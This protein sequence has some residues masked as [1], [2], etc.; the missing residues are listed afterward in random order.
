MI[1]LALMAG[2]F[3]AAVLL[4]GYASLAEEKPS[5]KTPAPIKPLPPA[6]PNDPLKPQEPTKPRPSDKTPEPRSPAVMGS[7]PDEATRA[8]L[9]KKVDLDFTDVP[10]QKIVDALSTQTK[11][12]I[13]VAAKDATTAADAESKHKLTVHL[14]GISA[15]NALN[16][17]TRDAG[18]GWFADQGAVV[19]SDDDHLPT[20]AQVYNVRDLV[21]AHPSASGPADE[22]LDY[23]Y[24]SLADVITGAIHSPTWSGNDSAVLQDC[25]PFHGTLTLTQDAQV[26]DQVAGLLAALRKSRDLRP[27]Q[28]DAT[29]NSGLRILDSDESSIEKALAKIVD[30]QPTAAKLDDLADWLRKTFSIAVHVDAHAREAGFPTS[31]PAVEQITGETS[32]KSEA[33]SVTGAPLGQALELLFAD[34]K[35]AYTVRDEVL[36][37]TT[38]DAE[39]SLRTVR[40]YPVGDLI[41]GD[42]DKDNVDD[43]YARLLDVITRSVEPDTWASLDKP[44]TGNAYI[45][46]LATGRAMIC[47]QS[48]DAHVHVAEMLAKVRKAVAE[49][50]VGTT[51]A[52]TTSTSSDGKRPLNMKIYK[53]NPDLAPEDFVAVIKD[54][55]EPKS[56][57]GD[58]YIH[59][60][61]GAIVVKQTG[62]IHKRV[63]KMLIDLGAIPDPKKSPPSGTPTLVGRGKAT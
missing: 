28:F 47:T 25:S 44:N 26:Q 38:K 41:G 43:E 2:L 39:K 4:G 59:G 49:Q 9:A 7:M 15:A 51:T 55:V 12:E 42:V 14:K 60:V 8:A 33:V 48:R 58:A 50:G 22:T 6:K 18:S 63:E 24:S 54:L 10:L 32:P 36:L 35:L 45:S 40:I 30:T 46:Y 3:S 57:T 56:W 61:P 5:A 20:V 21:L 34:S 27:Q 16:L 23:D 53:L 17:I 52:T 31:T 62:T 19:I 37:I 29:V 11:L 13:M 1:F